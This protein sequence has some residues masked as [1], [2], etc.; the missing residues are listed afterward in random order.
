MLGGPVPTGPIDP[1]GLAMTRPS[2]RRAVAAALLSLAMTS[3]VACGG[4]DDDEP[5]AGDT[6]SESASNDTSESPSDETSPSEE[7]TEDEPEAGSPV[8]NDEFMGVFRRAFEDATTAHMTM[9]SGGAGAELEAEGVADYSTT[10]LSMA[11]TMRSPQFGNGAAEMRLVDGVFYIKMPMLGKKFLK[12]DMDDPSNPFGTVL[13]DQMDPRTMFD[14]F[15]KGLKG[16]TFEGEEDVDGEPMDHYEVTVDSAV[17]L[18]ES[19][20]T[21]QPETNMPKEITY[22]M[23]FG[24]DGLFRMMR[25][26]FGEASGDMTVKYDQWGEPV[27]IEAPAPNEI[28]EMPGA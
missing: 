27:T 23:W 8:E 26:S 3:L 4:G 6:T 9:S 1:R 10:P 18:E 21:A 16:V 2:A 20:Q 14:A 15:E 24:E 19:G 5:T 13:T 22:G 11:M 17:I 12:F 28:S 7:A 25:V